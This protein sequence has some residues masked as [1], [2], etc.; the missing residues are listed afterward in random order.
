MVAKLLG[1]KRWH[2]ANALIAR[3]EDE[4]GVD[5]KASDNPY[6]VQ[7]KTGDGPGSRMHKY[8]DKAVELLKL[9]KANEKYDVSI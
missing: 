6:H 7:V 3:I 9:V 1:F 4:K 5:I 2:G 8:S